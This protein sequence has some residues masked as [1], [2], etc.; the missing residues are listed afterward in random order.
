[1]MLA[2]LQEPVKEAASPV[3]TSLL[4]AKA[5]SDRGNYPAKHKILQALLLSRPGEFTVDSREGNII[6]LT[7]I[8]G[9]RIHAPYYILPQTTPLAKTA[10]ES[11]LRQVA[12][13]A[14]HCR[15]K[16]AEL[17]RSKQP[18]TWLN[19]DTLEVFTGKPET[20]QEFGK[21]AWL[22]IKSAAVMLGDVLRPFFSSMQLIP[23]SFNRY[24]GGPTPLASMLAGGLLGAVGGNLTGRL[25]DRFAPAGSLEEGSLKRRGT[26]LGALLGATPGMLMGIHQTV[27]HPSNGLAALKAFAEPNPIFGLPNP[28]ETEDTGLFSLTGKPQ[29][30]RDAFLDA[31]DAC[32]ALQEELADRGLPCD[33]KGL[34]KAAQQ[35]GMGFFQPE[36][37]VNQFGRVIWADPLTPE[38]FR[39]AASGLVGAAGLM[40]NSAVVSPSDIARVALGMGSGAVMGMTAGRVLGSLAGLSPTAQQALQRGGMWAGLVKAVTPMAFGFGG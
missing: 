26:V 23:N 6:G 2:T 37:E 25:A 4:E 19:A 15:A 8:S 38:P 9:F 21:A 17:R 39:A 31:Q 36:I 33:S 24:L 20:F 34:Q 12:Q 5:E 32:Q 29:S 14:D 10:D 40:N 35:A 30:V 13:Y 11:L 7:H 18:L 27:H 3:I 1:M 28:P 16:V 22:P